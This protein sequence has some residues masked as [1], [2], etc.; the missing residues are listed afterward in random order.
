MVKEGMTASGKFIW[1]TCMLYGNHKDLGAYAMARAA[2]NLAAKGAASFKMDIRFLVPVQTEQS[3]MEEMER[4]VR[5]AAEELPL[6]E[7]DVRMEPA[8]ASAIPT[9]AVMAAGAVNPDG[10][11]LRDENGPKAGWDLV[12]TGWAGL[13]GTCR[14]LGEKEEELAL[15]FSQAFLRQIGSYGACIFALKEIEAAR[16]E[17]V[18]VIRQV[19]EGGILEALWDMAKETGLGISADMK[20]ISVKQETIEICE[21]FRLN[22]YQLSSTGALLMA[23]ERGEE[24]ADAL[25]EKGIHAAVI[26]RL[27]DGNDKIVRNG[28]EIRYIDRPVPDE[29]RKILKPV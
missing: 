26:G 21:Y 12:L 11:G 9:V 1:D 27:T 24:L 25:R 28:A 29:I 20:K 14:I 10:S 23:G 19:P 2:N 22:P 16:N 7:W 4:S 6:E 5:R 17:G 13:S 15:R 3:G 8:F 18:S